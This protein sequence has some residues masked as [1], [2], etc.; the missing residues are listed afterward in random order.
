MD[1]NADTYSRA[2]PGSLELFCL[3]DGSMLMTM[4]PGTKYKYDPLLQNE[5]KKS[6]LAR[7]SSQNVAGISECLVSFAVACSSVLF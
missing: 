5:T 3:G 1:A 2:H 4:P 6:S 7:L